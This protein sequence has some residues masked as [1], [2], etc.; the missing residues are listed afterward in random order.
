MELEGTGGDRLVSDRSGIYHRGRILR[1]KGHLSGSQW[2]VRH[3]PATDRAGPRPIPPAPDAEPSTGSSEDAAPCVT[4]AASCTACGPAGCTACGPRPRAAGDNARPGLTPAPVPRTLAS[5]DATLPAVRTARPVMGLPGPL[6]LVLGAV[7]GAGTVA[8]LMIERRHP[9]EVRLT[10][11]R[12][13]IPPREAA[14][15]LDRSDPIAVRRTEPAPRPPSIA[16][17]IASGADPVLQRLL[18]HETPDE[19]GA[20]ELPPSSGRD[21]RIP[22]ASAAR[23]ARP[24]GRAV[25]VVW[26]EMEPL[27]RSASPVLAPTPVYAAIATSELAATTGT[28]PMPAPAPV[29][30]ARVGS[31]AP[32]PT[33]PDVDPD[34]DGPCAPAR[35]LLQELGA[36]VLRARAIHDDA[37]ANQRRLQREYDAAEARIEAATRVMDG[38]RV[39]EE[40]EAAQRRFR[41]ERLAARD[42][43]E[44]EE[45]ATRWLAAIDALNV[46]VREAQRVLAAERRRAARLV[47]QIE[48]GSGRVDA[49]RIALE[50]AEQRMHQARETLAA[51]EELHATRLEAATMAAHATTPR[52]DARPAP[53]APAGVGPGQA[54][55]STEAAGGG[56]TAAE[57]ADLLEEAPARGRNVLARVLDGDEALLSDLVAVL[58]AGSADE[59]RRWHLELSAL[60]D[61]LTTAAIDAAALELPA[62]DPFWAPFSASEAREIAIALASLG[63]RYD[64]HGRFA[65]G[66]VPSTRDLALAVGYAGLDPRRIR[67]WPSA[68]EI[69][70]LLR[71]ARVAVGDFVA[72]SAP[73]LTLGQ[74]VALLGRQA[75]G[76][77]ALW[78]EWGRVRP[79]LARS[80]T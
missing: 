25:R 73:D 44:V 42:A 4:R 39:L 72:D 65:D 71:G 63:Y 12:N 64:G 1:K 11:T 48:A 3:L 67:R 79:L 34:A 50:T 8:W 32:E 20:L 15:P 43:R 33:A 38:R 74:M 19:V 61:A 6:L 2:G 18:A 7:I 29:P 49:A 52:P 77:A 41:T 45:A 27:G 31:P 21:E 26:Q 58:A 66:R 78:D 68:S 35:R 17:R 75:P 28:A 55:H 46:R 24:E 57:G 69:P 5:Q 56:S 22:T 40:K 62:D 36:V 51:C 30:A 60:R 80:A 53:P 23:V 59:A 9:A 10:I 70:L 13:A 14:T 54:S 76:L 47:A 16:L 37:V